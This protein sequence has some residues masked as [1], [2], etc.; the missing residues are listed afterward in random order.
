MKPM[1]TRGRSLSVRWHFEGDETVQPL[2]DA[3]EQQL[4]EAARMFASDNPAWRQRGR[5]RLRQAAEGLALWQRERLWQ[6]ARNALPEGVKARALRIHDEQ[7][8]AGN[9]RGA[10]SVAADATGVSARR[11]R[12]WRNTRAK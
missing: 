7:V 12:A 2:A 8:K 11:I 6:A 4:Q 3:I 5:Q 9:A 1:K 10:A